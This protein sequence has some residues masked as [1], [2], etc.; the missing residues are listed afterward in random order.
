VL[1]AKVKK[2]IVE[3]LDP[4]QTR[5]FEEQLKRLDRRSRPTRNDRPARTP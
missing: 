5:E 2:Q 1:A 4:E 3:L